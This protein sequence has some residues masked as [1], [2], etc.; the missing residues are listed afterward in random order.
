LGTPVRIQFLLIGT[1]AGWCSKPPNQVLRVREHP[2]I[3]FCGKFS[4]FCKFF[5]GKRN[6]LLQIPC[7]YIYINN[8]LNFK[9]N[10]THQHYCLEYEMVLKAFL[11]SY[12]VEP[13]SRSN[14][15]GVLRE[16]L[17]V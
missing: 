5:F 1:K 13:L 10:K 7:L 11:L 3:Y 14:R 4:P 12:F 16:G 17:L 9:K 2:M 6:T 15:H 8:K